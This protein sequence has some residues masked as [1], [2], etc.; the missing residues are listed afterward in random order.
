MV[1]KLV[2]FWAVSQHFYSMYKPGNI[3]F[4][5]KQQGLVQDIDLR[6]IRD[7]LGRYLQVRIMI[8]VSQPMERCLDI[9]LILGLE[10]GLLLNMKGYQIIIGIMV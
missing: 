4:L 1:F 10:L 2:V 7:C 6:D 3:P 9:K 8:D 5:G